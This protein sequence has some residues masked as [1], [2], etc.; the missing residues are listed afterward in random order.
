MYGECYK[1]T[2]MKTIPLYSVRIE[3]KLI[4]KKCQ[5]LQKTNTKNLDN[6]QK[7]KSNRKTHR[8]TLNKSF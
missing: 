7:S 2:A 5:Q 4:P 1:N 8:I 3:I 6:P